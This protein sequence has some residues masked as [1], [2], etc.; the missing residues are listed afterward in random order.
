MDLFGRNDRVRALLAVVCLA[1]SV[2][3]SAQSPSAVGAGLNEYRRA[4]ALL[5]QNIR[6]RFRNLS[7]RPVWLPDA[8]R[9]WYRRQTGGGWQYIAVDPE[10][11]RRQ[12][13]FDHARLASGLSQAL[14]RS[15]SP[16]H[17]PLDELQF[18][19]PDASVIR[20]A[21][22]AG[23]I[24]KCSL[25]RNT[26][27]IE[28]RLEAAG[29]LVAPD[30]SRAALI[31]NDNVWLRMLPEGAER[32]LTTDGQPDF[33]YGHAPELAYQAAGIQTNR[34]PARITGLY[35]SPD[36]RLLVAARSDERSVPDFAYIDY[37][38]LNG[39]RRPRIVRG[40]HTLAGE[41]ARRLTDVSI[42][43]TQTG[44]KRSID[45]GGVGL[46]EQYWWHPSGKSFLALRRATPRYY[47]REQ[48]LVEVTV[49]DA[50]VR[51]IVR[52]SSNT[53]LQSTAIPT[54]EP[55]V[56]YLPATNEAIWYS[57]RSG[58]G[59]LYLV[60]VATGETRSQITSGEGSVHCIIQVDEKKRRVYFTATG[61]EPEQNPYFR[62][63][64]SVGFDG[65]DLRLLTPEPADHIFPCGVNPQFPPPLPAPPPDL[66]SPDGQYVIDT[67]S[68]VM[69]EPVSVLKRIDGRKIMTL[70]KGDAADA[71]RAG[72]TAPEPFVV[73]A[74]DGVT[75]LYG[76]IFK[77]TDFKPDRRYPV[78]NRIYGGPQMVITPHNF[79][80]AALDGPSVEAQSLAQLGFVVVILDGRG[81]PMRSKRFHDYAFNTLGDRA[82]EDHVAAIKELARRHAYLDL[83]R[84][85]VV[86]NTS[87]LP[88]RALVRYPQV[89]KA[90]VATA[91]IHDLSYARDNWDMLYVPPVSVSDRPSNWPR[92]DVSREVDRLRGH[93]L[94]AY[95]DLD[96]N[97]YPV[98]AVNLIDALIKAN[99]D[100]ELV[101]LPGRRHAID[102]ESYLVRRQWDFLV[103]HLQGI[104]P[105]RDYRITAPQG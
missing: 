89:F 71:R 93:L 7:L 63:L 62:H 95:G 44:T 46:Y 20:F 87:H 60:D 90:A 43:D 101:Y 94:L 24:A 40:K 104:E 61:R 5:P 98:D 35:W 80:D 49:A 4:E 59:H 51:T 31:R 55:A 75:D 16:Q 97:V 105:P 26:C 81:T 47:L 73:K 100:F 88:L 64:Y 102:N 42:I 96:D 77:P 92:I 1:A 50:S 83:D 78:I 6:H 30:G 37:L 29:L 48:E 28:A 68:T 39:D 86:G 76:V 17:L 72:W 38:P 84:V 27:Q 82:L 18:A 79:A 74:A 52:D 36:S 91:N 3:S 12:P 10:A 65:S 69:Q 99:K 13:A 66:I 32:A 19:S 33:A 23:R 85:G 25:I 34:V 57:Q 45:T 58:W 14:A 41:G 56:R 11:G 67:Y 103:R 53:F 9:F 54:D 70:E 8:K 2:A 22:D 21:V 15:V